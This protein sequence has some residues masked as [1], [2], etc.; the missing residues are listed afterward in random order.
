VRPALSDFLTC[1]YVKDLRSMTAMTVVAGRESHA[2]A[3]FVEGNRRL[4]DHYVPVPGEETAKQRAA[5]RDL[6]DSWVAALDRG[7]HLPPEYYE[8]GLMEFFGRPRRRHCCD[9]DLLGL[10]SNRLPAQS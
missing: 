1:G 7:E 5:W 9:V 2:L 3:P 10:I 8:R 6:L 4:L